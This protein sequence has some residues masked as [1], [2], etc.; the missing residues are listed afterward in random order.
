MSFDE[1]LTRI[2]QRITTYHRLRRAETVLSDS[3]LAEAAMLWHAAQPADGDHL[4]PEGNR[5]LAAA[6]HALGWLHFCRHDALPADR[7]L[8]ELARA[9]VFLGALAQYL[10]AI[11]E[12]LRV[13]LGVSAEASAQ[14]DLATRMLSHAETTTDPVLIH[15]SI[16]LLTAALAATPAGHH[17]DQARFLSN[18]GNAYQARFEHG[19][20]IAD[21]DRAIEAG[22]Q[23]VAT[24]SD[25]SPTRAG[26]LS[27]LGIAYWVRF[28]HGGAI[29]DLDRAIE[30]ARQAVATTTDGHLNRARF[31]CGLGNGYRAR[32]EHGG[33]VADL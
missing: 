27:N 31:L 1:R 10:E 16:S 22:K 9:I 7:N 8:P 25:D 2:Q 18:L 32:F 17:P 23:A 3:A 6:H 29:A 26:R 24:T 19:G 14:A 30:A 33:V 20:A 21:L 13:V 28:E 5:R 15:A 4:A 12:P 11:P